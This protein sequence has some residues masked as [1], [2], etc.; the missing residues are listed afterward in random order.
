MKFTKTIAIIAIS[1]LAVSASA[2]NDGTLRRNTMVAQGDQTATQAQQ[3]AVQ[4]PVTVV[5]AAPVVESKAEVL[6]K[7]RQ[8]A[9]VQT[10][11]KIVEKLEDSRL[12]EERQRADRLFGNKMDAP[13]AAV[14]AAPAPAP[15]A[16]ILAPVAAPV[17]VQEKPAQPAQV[18]IEKV[19]IIQPTAKA[20]K[21]EPVAESKME[22]KAETLVESRSRYYVSGLA[23][24][25]NYSASNV[26]SNY[27]LGVAVGTIIDDK[28]AV[29]LSYFYS[30]H[31]IDDLW[32]Q[33]VYH[34]LDQSD[35]SGAA[36]Y[37]FL[38]GKLKPYAGGSVT[39][40]NRKYTD[41]VYQ[42][43][44]PGNNYSTTE[45]T[46]AINAGV[47]GGVDFALS[48]SFMLG[49]GA[50]YSFNVMNV[51]SFNERAYNL[52]SGSQELEK[53]SYWTI[54]VTGKFVF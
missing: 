7:T 36:K 8:D 40:I 49:A 22:T 43:Y 54:K 32:Q 53:M 4:Q 27:G 5:E 23:G 30:N 26:K 38:S 10:E 51:N 28:W 15:A 16:P 18:T 34:K 33:T 25:I 47:L 13:A 1:V 52:P 21:L 29:E 31:N 19:E 17:I 6:R 24:N 45:S 42:Y 39:Y 46:S 48:D 2:N 20:E 50:D 41:R 12:Q 44:Y 37:Y 11:Q 35:I 3:Q 9:E 14:V